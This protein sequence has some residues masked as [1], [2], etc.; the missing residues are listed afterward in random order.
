MKTRPWIDR[1]ELSRPGDPHAEDAIMAASSVLFSMSG[2]RF[3]GLWSTT[4]QYTCE[5]TGAPTGCSYDPGMGGYWNP[6]LGVYTY[7]LGRPPGL[8][9]SGPGGDIRLNMRPVREITE[10]MVDGEVV[11]PSQYVLLNKAIFRS[12]AGASWGLCSSPLI[13][14]T[15]GVTPPAIGKLAARRLADEFVKMYNGEECALPSNTTSVARQGITIS[16]FDPQDFFDKGL[17]GIYEVDMF[18]KTINPSRAA[19]RPRVFSPDF[20]RPYRRS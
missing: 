12:A 8:R 2:L 1:S 18:L 4:E 19:N 20:P 17:V 16:V 7:V 11:D 9:R 3:S 13:T 15:Y 10:V 14:Y 5:T 6:S